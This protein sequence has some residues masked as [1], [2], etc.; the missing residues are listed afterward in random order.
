MSL[1]WRE[2]ITFHPELQ[3][4]SCWPAVNVQRMDA[5]KRK[6]YLRNLKIVASVLDDMPYDEIAKRNNVT[7]GRISQLMRRCLQPNDGKEDLPLTKG[8]I[9]GL[10]I[11]RAEPSSHITTL[12]DNVGF[13]GQFRRLL[14]VN[15]SILEKLSFFITKKLKDRPE[16][17][18]IL[19][20]WFHAEFKRILEELNLPKN[21][22]PY[23][24]GSIAYTSVSRLLKKLL[25]KEYLQRVPKRIE[26]I[27]P[28]SQI[29]KALRSIEID[30][31]ITD[32]HSSFHLELNDGLIPLRLA[33]VSVIVAIDSDTQCV[34]AFHL[35]LT[36][37]PSQED[38][39]SLLE[40]LM[41][42]DRND[43]EI[44]TPGIEILPDAEIPSLFQDNG[45]LLP[46]DIVKLDNALIHSATSVTSTL[47]NC[48][49][50]TL[51]FGPAGQPVVRHQVEQAMKIVNEV[52][53]RFASTTGSSVTDPIRESSKL[54]K[55]PPT[56]N[57]KVLEEAIFAV[58][59]NHNA[60]LKGHLG[61]SSPIQ[62]FNYQKENMWF[63]S[64]PKQHVDTFNPFTFDVEVPVKFY[65][66]E[67]RAPFINFAHVRYDGKCLSVSD[68]IGKSIRIRV[69]RKDV[70]RV[71]AYN[72][73]GLYLGELHAPKSWLYFPHSLKLRQIIMKLVKR[74]S[75]R[76]K[77]PLIGY[78]NLIMT[79]K[80]HPK[81]ALQL[82]KLLE[83]LNLNHI[84][85][86]KN[87]DSK[88][89]TQKRI[90]PPIVNS[91]KFDDWDDTWA[92]SNET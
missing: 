69:N 56:T 51:H 92:M 39:L 44:T 27:V 41:V 70:R 86:F 8:L 55:K 45:T 31:Q 36:S 38:M 2:Q 58:F 18:T 30:E 33:R 14:E 46:P 84:N 76:R 47:S 35:C 72:C 88:L 77:D 40:K 68:V 22:Y 25:A 10:H 53:H 74:D 52:T 43:Y 87:S 12:S 66:N 13:R 48:L 4:I 82:Y 15:P 17:H 81:Y 73:E 11:R 65:P 1:N 32:I 42:K 49:G 28:N 20:R 37:S 54:A 71:K 7:T 3:D 23:N 67:N 75:L 26:K 63:R 21:E 9:P 6:K 91:D 85:K 89:T 59:A 62:T 5:N 60:R 64:L 90:V 78:A 57:I 79:K 80:K 19:P 24:T 34:F 29:R 50:A 83:S 16:A 61:G